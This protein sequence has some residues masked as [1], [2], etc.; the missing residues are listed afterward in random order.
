MRFATWFEEEQ[1]QLPN[2]QGYYLACVLTQLGHDTLFN[3]VDKV[4][5]RF[6]PDR[7]LQNIPKNWRRV[8]H[9]MTVKFNPTISDFRKYEKFFGQEIS[10]NVVG[11]AVDQYAVAVKVMPSPHV[12]SANVVP[13][14]T[15]AHSDQV[16]PVYSNE[17]FELSELHPIN[18]GNF[19]SEFL[20][21]K[22]DKSGYWP[23]PKI[24]M[25]SNSLFR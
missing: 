14:I 23:E 6:S 17:L 7:G 13:H 2:I 8:C 12:D 16:R 9:H 22:L 25:A 1:M 18:L 11:I 21:V 3:A 4:F 20:A 5:G 24:A 19:S 10:L 15:I